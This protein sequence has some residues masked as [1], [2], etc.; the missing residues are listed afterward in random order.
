[1]TVSRTFKDPRFARD[2]IIS[3]TFDTLLAIQELHSPGHLVF[4]LGMDSFITLPQWHK[5]EQLF[6]MC[7]FMILARPGVTMQTS[8][9]EHMQLVDRRVNNGESLF[10][11]KA[12]NVFFAE[13]FQQNISSSRV[14][15]ALHSGSDVSTLLDNGVL[16]YI[17]SNKL[18]QRV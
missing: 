17:R 12:G 10:S 16:A 4:V 7:H 9:E 5:W 13:D 2:P 3:Y 8:V 6:K 11:S 18:Y 14:R 1:M 15:E